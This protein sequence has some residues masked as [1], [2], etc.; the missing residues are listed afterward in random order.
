MPEGDSV[1]KLAAYLS[2]LLTGRRLG[3]VRL[4]GHPARV[5]TGRRVERVH[6]H[7]KHLYIHFDDGHVLRSHLGMYG[8]WHHY[9][10]GEA[11]RRPPSQAAIELHCDDEVLACFNP[12]EVAL[13]P[14]AHI[15][16][17]GRTARPGPDLLDAR[18]EPAAIIA[19]ARAL[20]DEG[21]PMADVLLDQRVAA[22]IGNVYKCELLFLTGLDPLTP[23]GQ[24]DDDRLTR[25]YQ[26]ASELLRNNLG[27]GPRRTRSAGPDEPQLW[28]YRRAGRPCL[29][30]GAPIRYARLGR[31][32]RP[33][34]WCAHCQ[35]CSPAGP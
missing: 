18:V 28:V 9:R 19:R 23:L 5:L 32:L 10:S 14:R 4:R 21:T 6:A 27:P 15:R 17:A 12:L 11:W 35:A 33:T 20:L 25:L 34:Y 16:P 31:H 30:C 2:E 22:G 3:L 26:L 8:S 29:R 1:H 7:G 24:V 13:A